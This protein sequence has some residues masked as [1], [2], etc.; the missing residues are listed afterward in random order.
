MPRRKSTEMVGEKCE[1]CGKTRGKL[2]VHH[3]DE[4]PTNNSPEN[5][6]TLCVSCHRLLHSPNYTGTP[7]RRKPCLLCNKPSARR[8][9]CNTHLSRLK[10]HGDPL[11]VTRGNQYGTWSERAVL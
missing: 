1:L 7:P 10:R 8:G 2:H 6:Q 5:L 3:L 9:Y 11:A 4:N